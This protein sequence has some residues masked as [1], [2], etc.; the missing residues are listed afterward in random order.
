MNVALAVSFKLITF[1]KQYNASRTA[2]LKAA[3]LKR[4]K[5]AFKK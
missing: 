2:R 5:N 1:Y 4:N 3:A